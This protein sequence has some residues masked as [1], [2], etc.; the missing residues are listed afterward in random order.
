MK[1]V[2]IST[3]DLGHGAGIAA[4]RLHRA[5]VEARADAFMLVSQKLSNDPTVIELLPP[6]GGL[7]RLARGGALLLERLLNVS[8]P[9]N[10][11]SV[12]DTCLQRHLDA[13]RPDVIHL[14][15]L[16]WH[17]RNLSLSLI[18]RLGRRAP[19]VW[20]FHDMWAIT[21]HCIYSRD[22]TRWRLGCGGC[23]YVRAYLGQLIDTSMLQCRLKRRIYAESTFTV[24]TPSKWLADCAEASPLLKDPRIVTIP[25][26]VDL[27]T[28]YPRDKAISWAS[29]GLDAEDRPVLLFISAQL[30]NPLKG[31]SYFEAALWKLAPQWQRKIVVVFVGQ[32]EV[33]SALKE[34]FSVVELGFVDDPG[35]MSEIFAAVDL[36]VIPSTYDN[37]PSVVLESS[38]CGTPVVGFRTGG[39]PD[40]IRDG[41]TGLIADYLDVDDLTRCIECLLLD[42]SKRRAMGQ[43]ARRLMETEYSP[44]VHAQRCLALYREL[45]VSCERN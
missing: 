13:I 26:S 18:K 45:L 9:Q 41:V 6:V 22:C 35:R 11:Y 34:S 29:L 5:L 27:E 14:H 17:S 20:T 44:T 32:G 3:S 15:N 7:K 8:G 16:H 23:P 42:E 28:F 10:L 31:Y 1:V 25:N 37:L 24:V 4:Y 19:L 38:A 43:A 36:Y 40:M 33:S 30:D 12:A 39:I 21:G 2:T